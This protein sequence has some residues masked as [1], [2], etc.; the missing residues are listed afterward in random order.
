MKGAMRCGRI[1]SKEDNDDDVRA[2]GSLRPR[3]AGECGAA[4]GR[5]CQEVIL[6]IAVLRER[7]LYEQSEREREREREGGK[8]GEEIRIDK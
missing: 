3:R 6:K 1:F 4:L 2:Q 5:H 7:V 8:E